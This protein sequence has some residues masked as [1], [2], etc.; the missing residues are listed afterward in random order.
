MFQ[1]GDQ[2]YCFSFIFCD[3]SITASCKPKQRYEQPQIK[4][5]I[6]FSFM[7]H[8]LAYSNGKGKTPHITLNEQMKTVPGSSVSELFE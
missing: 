1:L 6:I 3:L 5:E 7:F 8:S 4:I 2:F